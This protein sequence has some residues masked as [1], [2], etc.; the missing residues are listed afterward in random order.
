MMKYVG[1]LDYDIVACRDVP[2]CGKIISIQYILLS[3]IVISLSDL[4][5]RKFSTHRSQLAEQHLRQRNHRA[6]GQR[7][8][9]HVGQLN[10][11][12]QRLQ[13]LGGPLDHHVDVG[14]SVRP[15]GHRSDGDRLA[16]I[17]DV[18]GLVAIHLAT[19][20]KCHTQNANK[21]NY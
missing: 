17:L 21:K 7:L 13:S 4:V 3:S 20:T 6:V 9:A 12:A 8:L 19:I 5:F 1:P 11:G 14:A 15:G 10:G 18:L 2:C 16:Q